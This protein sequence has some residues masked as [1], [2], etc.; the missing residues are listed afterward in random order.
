MEE[1]ECPECGDYRWGTS[2]CT[3]PEDEWIGHCHGDFCNFTWPRKDDHLYFRVSVK[4]QKIESIKSRIQ[5]LVDLEPGTVWTE[6]HWR[7]A[8]QLQQ[9]FN[10]LDDE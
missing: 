10:N 2:N 3:S 8:L 6:Y 5:S 1:F 9:E 7:D 4:S